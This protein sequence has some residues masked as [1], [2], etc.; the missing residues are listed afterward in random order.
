MEKA[1]STL[2]KSIT[3]KELNIIF[4]I[5]TNSN[6]EIKKKTKGDYIASIN[7]VIS[8]INRD[9]ALDSIVI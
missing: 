3:V 8:N 5:L 7:N 1:D 4:C 9:K 6:K 2:K